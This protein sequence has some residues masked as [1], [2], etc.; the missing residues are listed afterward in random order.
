M[1]EDDE[2]SMEINI[3]RLHS[4][5]EHIGWENEHVLK[6]FEALVDRFKWQKQQLH[7]T[8][9][10]EK[11]M[12]KILYAIE[13][14]KIDA[15]LKISEYSNVIQLVRDFT[16][17][18]PTLL[19]LLGSDREKDLEEILVDIAVQHGVHDNLIRKVRIIVSNVSTALSLN[20]NRWCED[21]MEKILFD[22]CKAVHAQTKADNAQNAWMPRYTQMV[23]WCILALSQNSYLLQVGT[24]EG[25]SCIV[26]MFAAYRARKGQKVDIISSSSVL[27][28]RDAKAWKVFYKQLG[29]TVDCNTHKS[30]ERL[31]QCYKCHVVYGTTGDF[32]GDWLRHHFSRKD[33]RTGRKFECVIVDEVDSLML[34]KGLEV[35]YLSSTMPAMQGLEVLLSRIWLVACQNEK[36]CW[37]ETA[38]PVQSIVHILQ[39]STG[40]D[41]QP[42]LKLAEERGIFPTGFAKDIMQ[43]NSQDVLQKLEGISQTQIID[44]F[45][46]VEEKLPNYSFSLFQEDGQWKKS[47]AQIGD[48]GNCNK[49]PLL[50]LKGGL[51]RRLFPDKEAC[52]NWVEQTIRSDLQFICPEI[53]PEDSPIPGMQHFIQAKLRVWV[54][55][56][57]QAK[58]MDLGDEYIIQ[59]QSVVPVDYTCTGVVQNNMRWSNGLQQ[60]LEMKHQTKLSSMTAITNFM[61]NVRLFRMYNGQVYGIS[62]TLGNEEEIQMLQE[63][64]EDMQTCII[65]SF[66]RRKLFEET[67][68]IVQGEEVWLEAICSAVQEKVSETS[69]CGERA[70]LVIC[71]TINRAKAI[72]TAIKNSLA[73]LSI[74]LK[75]YTNS[76]L[77]PTE[78]TGRPLQP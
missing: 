23:S 55:S 10:F 37:G 34:D 15:T 59:G 52:I 12:A 36:M 58:E 33:I 39:E 73:N 30:E 24:G 63:L 40:T 19:K 44:F 65:P 4:L 47:M 50:F 49:I 78:I 8:V 66:K 43:P 1:D 11:W 68:I 42:F 18:D 3:P 54:Q 21:G 7:Q 6:L 22:L 16:I 31:K 74:H 9:H 29:L 38:G 28:E 75:L 56:A 35:V 57:F 71:E 46:V 2:Y 14:H 48:V 26:A 61:S 64:Y 76:N 67:G 69:Y 41:V 77:D 25:K 13:I 32:A 70:V 72:E 53:T 60:F 51:C 20:D 27:A 45:K 17:D 5:S 62:G